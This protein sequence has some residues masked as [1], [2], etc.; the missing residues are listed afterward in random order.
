MEGSD[1]ENQ[2]KTTKEIEVPENAVSDDESGNGIIKEKLE[3]AVTNCHS[4]AELKK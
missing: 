4:D 3:K 2:R 1:V